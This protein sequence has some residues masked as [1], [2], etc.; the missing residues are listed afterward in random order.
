LKRSS[1]SF[2]SILA[3]LDLASFW[4]SPLAVIGFVFLAIIA[5]DRISVHAELLRALEEDGL[6]TW[7][8]WYGASGDGRLAVVEF[9][10]L[11]N[12]LTGVVLPTKYYQPETLAALRDGQQVRVRY[13]HPPSHDEAGVLAGEM[14]HVRGYKGHI[15]GLFWPFLICWLAAAAHPEWLCLGFLDLPAAPTGKENA[16]WR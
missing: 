8:R 12:G 16:G 10:R 4:L 6:E 9:D 11:E 14:S 13:V 5:V 7:G 3:G 2:R 1:Q 15:T